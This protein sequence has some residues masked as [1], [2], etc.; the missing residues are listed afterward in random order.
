MPSKYRY[1]FVNASQ[2]TLQIT[3]EPLNWESLVLTFK[4]SEDFE[5]VTKDFSQDLTFWGDANDY[6]RL[7]YD[8]TGINSQVEVTIDI[9]DIDTFIY[10]ELFLG[11]INFGNYEEEITAKGLRVVNTNVEASLFETQVL[12]GSGIS[13]DV[14]KLEDR[15]GD[16]ITPFPVYEEIKPALEGQ[17]ITDAFESL[18]SPVTIDDFFGL[19]TYS[20]TFPLQFFFF[21]FSL[22]VDKNSVLDITNPPTF[23]G[24]TDPPPIWKV[25]NRGETTI[26]VDI[27]FNVD[28]QLGSGELS[29]TSDQAIQILFR[30]STF[31]I[32]VTE[33]I[34]FPRTSATTFDQD[35]TFTITDTRV[36]EA[37]DQVDVFWSYD[38]FAESGDPIEFD[39]FRISID[40]YEFSIVQNTDF[41]RTLPRGMF[42]F[43]IFSRVVNFLTGKPNRVIGDIISRTNQNFNPA[44]TDGEAS[45]VMVA[46]G[47]GLRNFP[48][49]ES[50]LV[51]T[52]KDLFSSYNY[53]FN[54]GLGFVQFGGEETVLVDDISVFYND[55]VILTLT[56]GIENPRLSLDSG[57]HWSSLQFGFSKFKIEDRNFQSNQE[58][59]TQRLYNSAVQII[60]QDKTILSPFIGAGYPIEYQRREQWFP[61]TNTQR[62]DQKRF[63]DDK[64]LLSLSETLT[65]ERTSQAI[66][67]EG[68]ATVFWILID[69]G[70][71]SP[72]VSYRITNWIEVQNEILYN[73][74][75]PG[76]ANS[77]WKVTDNLDTGNFSL[78]MGGVMNAPADNVDYSVDVTVAG[79]V[80]LQASFQSVSVIIF[81]LV[82]KEG[83]VEIVADQQNFSPSFNGEAFNVFLSDNHTILTTDE[84]IIYFWRIAS[85]PIGAS[86]NIIL[87]FSSELFFTMTIDT[88]LQ[89]YRQE[90]TTEFFDPAVVIS[91][92]ANDDTAL[93]FRISPRQAIERHK[94]TLSAVNHRLTPDQLTFSGDPIGNTL[95]STTNPTFAE[96]DDIDTSG[97]TLFENELLEFDVPWTFAESELVD[98]NRYGS[99]IVANTDITFEGYIKDIEHQVE[100][101]KAKVTLKRKGTP[102]GVGPVAPNAPTL[103][104]VV[105]NPGNEE[106]QAL[107]DWTSNSGGTEDGFRIERTLANPITWGTAGE[108][109]TGVETFIDT[110]LIANTGYTYRV[111]AL[112]TINSLPSNEITVIT[113]GVPLAPANFRIES[114][115]PAWTSLL[116]FWDD[117]P[118]IDDIEIERSLALGG[119]FSPLATVSPGVE[120]YF[121]GGLTP[122]TEYFYRIN[123]TNA[124]GDGPFAA[125]SR[126]TN[127][128]P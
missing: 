85:V 74:G 95:V 83:P 87:Q 17:V 1:T 51:V 77:S 118:N 60:D 124:S 125:E 91:N 33:E 48:D 99:I 78:T 45:K 110:G 37:G 61:P 38:L 53:G 75:A 22:G 8:E 55:T 24:T 52:L 123:G 94:E 117:P 79:E 128:Q 86:G 65:T 90:K 25:V 64:F 40:S 13:V 88:S 46:S 81:Q 32:F 7:V 11:R 54:I 111:V 119:P 82:R 3:N 97:T 106:T 59:N 100:A 10:Q 63:D 14:F 84:D 73:N 70:S 36:F 29:A 15:F 76:Y 101:G 56:E 116:L 102:A 93:N 112:S 12:S 49:D 34:T 127:E 42:P 4:R 113:E 72:S 2:G 109:A 107:L 69:W 108:V 71:A 92:L 23:I 126:T 9:F 35:F 5:G 68:G 26:S 39:K 30:S 121:D 80:T 89:E 57:Q 104:T 58:F 96:N 62:P 18:V 66:L 41:A 47:R 122:D 21:S 43:E 20:E 44:S 115:T 120:F 98:A 28:I 31:A 19:E 50:P 6:L 103:D 67:N 27:T 16:A 114:F 105:P